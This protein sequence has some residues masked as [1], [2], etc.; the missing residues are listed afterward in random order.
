MRT[1]GD[2]IRRKERKQLTSRDHLLMNS[3]KIYL[4]PDKT[5]PLSR[6]YEQPFEYVTLTD[7]K[8]RCLTTV[9]AFNKEEQAYFEANKR[10][11]SITMKKKVYDRIAAQKAKLFADTVVALA[12][13]PPNIPVFEKNGDILLSA[14]CWFQLRN[15]K[16]I[17]ALSMGLSTT[18]FP[19]VPHDAQNVVHEP[20]PLDFELASIKLD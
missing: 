18:D 2:P 13:I 8:E 20:S 1:Q 9:D 7:K 4:I 6:F 15:V 10:W 14:K 19:A 11:F 3:S 17:K 5:H 16:G 12:K